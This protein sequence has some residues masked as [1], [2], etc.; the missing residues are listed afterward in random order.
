MVIGDRTFVVEADVLE[1]GQW[2]VPVRPRPAMLAPK[3]AGQCGV[4]VLH[5]EACRV[6]KKGVFR[7][8][9]PPQPRSRR[10]RAGQAYAPPLSFARHKRT[11]SGGRKHVRWRYGDMLLS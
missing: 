10:T 9:A 6:R 2:L 5:E 4:H 1:P 11:P 8:V 7:P 3:R